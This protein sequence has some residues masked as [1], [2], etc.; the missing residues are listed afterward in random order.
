MAGL[1]PETNKPFPIRV[2]LLHST[3][4][5][6]AISERD[7]ISAAKLAIR[8]INDRGGILG[9]RKIEAIEEDGASDVS[10]FRRKASKLVDEDG[11][12]S[13]FGCWTSA[14]R[15]AVL[16]VFEGRNHLLWYPVQYE[17][18]E[19]SPNVVYT[20]SAPNQQILPA[21][22]YCLRELRRKRFLLV[23]SDYVFPRKANRIVRAVLA[24]SG[25]E[26]VGE[27]YQPLEK[28]NFDP[29]LEIIRTKCPDVIFNTVNGQ[30]NIQLFQTL[31]AAGLDATTLPVMS[32]SIAEVELDV[33]GWSLA[34]GHY[35]AWSYFESLPSSSNQRFK[36]A[37]RAEWGQGKKTDDPIEAA[38]SQVHLFARAAEKARSSRP[39]D[40]RAA[41]RGLEFEA[42]GGVIRIDEENQHAWKVARIGRILPTEEI[43]IM[44]SSQAPI[45]PDP[46]LKDRFPDG[47]AAMQ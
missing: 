7:L 34:A 18:D 2:G 1:D 27:D 21:I 3:T 29:M 9:G 28:A 38:Y 30:G 39:L 22:D 6:M 26:C 10:V 25:V 15:Q 13:V 37:Y 8:E 20:G 43:E 5:P 42:P 35:C 46:Y 24:Q 23:G 47:L 45:R 4:G 36:E 14:S 40:I 16:P 17:G 44:W 33:I 32:V 31:R 19:S 41:V 11:V 12:S